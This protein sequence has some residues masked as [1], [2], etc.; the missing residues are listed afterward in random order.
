MRA[1]HRARRRAWPCAAAD[2]GPATLRAPVLARYTSPMRWSRY[3]INTAKEDPS[4]AEVEFSEYVEYGAA[5]YPNTKVVTWAA[6]KSA[7][8]KVV[9]Y[10]AKTGATIKSFYP[11][12]IDSPSEINLSSKGALGTK[13]EEFYKRFR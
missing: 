7:V 6:D 2:N 4:E 9:K 3:P 8:I 10:S 12:V 5:Q 11:E 13:I 1:H